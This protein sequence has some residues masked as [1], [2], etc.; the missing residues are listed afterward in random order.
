MNHIHTTQHP[1][2]AAVHTGS[3]S[4][5]TLSTTAAAATANRNWNINKKEQ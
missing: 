1:A 3:T 5:N 4:N 2:V